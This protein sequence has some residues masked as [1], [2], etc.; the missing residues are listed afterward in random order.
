[1]GDFLVLPGTAE[2]Q[3]GAPGMGE[4]DEAERT[5]HAKKP[6]PRE[7]HE[8]RVRACL[9]ESTALVSRLANIEKGNDDLWPD[10]ADEFHF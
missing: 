10:F 6:R 3:R 9:G 7:R 8:K 4:R 1:L 5:P 2:V